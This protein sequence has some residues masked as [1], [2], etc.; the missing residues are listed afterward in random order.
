M[1]SKKIADAN[2]N[3]IVTGNDF[4]DP[5]LT[6]WV[7]ETSNLENKNSKFWEDFF[8]KFSPIYIINGNYKIDVDANKFIFENVAIY[9]NWVE[10][11]SVNKVSVKDASGKLYN[12]FVAHSLILP[13]LGQVK[14][15]QKSA[16]YTI[17]T[18]SG[19]T[20]GGAIVTES[21]RQIMLSKARR[22]PYSTVYKDNAAIFGTL[23]TGSLIG[24]GLVYIFN[25]ANSLAYK[26]KNRFISCINFVPYYS[27]EQYFC[28]RR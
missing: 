8:K 16:G 13:G 2:L 18:F 28:S 17:M 3:F 22:N 10:E 11:S 5:E 23:R 7:Y 27:N 20:I 9:N 26:P 24:F 25:I 12:K 1:L 19:I 14:R 6:K 15:E 21:L 4:E